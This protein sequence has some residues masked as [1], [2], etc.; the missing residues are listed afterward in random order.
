MSR[1]AL[2]R[3]VVIALLTVAVALALTGAGDTVLGHMGLGPLP[4]S[5]ARYLDEAF[6]RSMKTFGLLSAV[7]V[8]LAVVEGTEVGVGFGLQVGDAVQS[9]YDYIDVAW[10]TV[11]AGGVVLVGTRY[12][13]EAAALAGRW[14]LGAACIAGLALALL[15]CWGGR[16]RRPRDVLRDISLVLTVTAAA[17][18]VMLP[19]AVG[20]ARTLS[21]QV[22]EPSLNEVD[23]EL[24]TLREELEARDATR[25]GLM[26]Q[27]GN[28]TERVKQIATSLSAR[29]KEASVWAFRLVAGY[30]FDCIVFPLGLFVLLLWATKGIARYAYGYRRN[31]TLREDLTGILDSYFARRGSNAHDHAGAA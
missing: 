18:Y 21:R 7:K 25:A 8:G 14:V 10:R 16:L 27:L 30:L 13:L 2:R 12:L 29:S 9:T 24:Q 19:L 5:S 20:G 1:S 6:G 28:A 22:I 11:L 31:R 17:I 23:Q 3:T 15:G 4:A 26:H